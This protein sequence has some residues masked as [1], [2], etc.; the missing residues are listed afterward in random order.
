M[1][2]IRDKSEKMSAY[3][4]MLVEKQVCVC[5]SVF[6]CVCVCQVCVC[7]SVVM[8]VCV[9]QVCVCPSVFMCVSQTMCVCHV[10]VYVPLC[11]SQTNIRLFARVCAPGGARGSV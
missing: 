9:C 6:V 10:C 8:C 4:L 11:V 5:P 1:E 7:P 3:L 2:A